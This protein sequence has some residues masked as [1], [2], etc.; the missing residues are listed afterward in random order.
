MTG[1]L[2][3]VL[4]IVACSFDSLAQIRKGSTMLGGHIGYTS[5]HVSSPSP[6]EA[7]EVD[8]LNASILFGKAIKENLFLGL[9]FNM[10][11]SH[12]QY[13]DN[14]QKFNSY[15]GGVFVRRYFDIGKKFYFFTQAHSGISSYR[16]DQSY[17]TPGSNEKGYVIHLGFYPGISYAITRRFHIESGFN[18]LVFANL[19]RIKYVGS[20]NIPGKKTNFNISTNIDNLSSLSIGVRFLFS[21]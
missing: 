12:R 21:E 10:A 19:T 6:A 5:D 14:T 17:F 16:N 15:G 13:Q 4:F 3:F 1:K 9:S 8:Y 2:L 20:S 11:F 18:N 7:S